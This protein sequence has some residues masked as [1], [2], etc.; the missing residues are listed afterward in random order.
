MTGTPADAFARLSPAMQYQV[1]NGLG[2]SELRLVQQL[3]THAILDGANCVVLAP[4]AGGKTEAAFFPLLSQMDREDWAPVS[5]LYIAPIR[6]LLNNQDSRLHK[7]TALVGRTAG[8]WHG[9]VNASARKNM[10]A[11]PPDVLAITPESLEAML[12]STKVPARRLLGKVR[13]VV[14]DEVHAFAGDDRGAHLVAL[15]ERISRIAEGDIQRIGLSATVGDPEIILQWLSGSS[16]RPQRIVNPGGKRTPPLISVDFVGS[17]DNAAMMIDQ[18]YPGTRRLVFVDSRRRVE[19]LGHKLSARGVNVYLSHSSLAL[20]E[21]AAAEKAFEEGTNCVIVATSA[22]ELGIDVGDL[23]HVIQV[24]APGTVSSC[25]QRMGRT[26]RRA[27]TRAN[28]TFLATDEAALLQ[29]VALV[30]L[31]EQGFV[32]PAGPT[33]WAPHVLAHQAIALAMQEQ[34]VAVHDWW[35]WLEGCAA[36]RD[37]S[38]E[39]RDAVV[40]HMVTENILVEADHRLVLGSKGEKLYGAKNFLELYAV[41]STPQSIRVMH[42]QQEVGI[43]DAFFLQDRD[44][45]TPSFVLGGRAWRILAVDW[46]GATCAVEPGAAG[47]YPSWFGQPIMLSRALCQS[48]R[49]LLVDDQSR[50][51]WSK[52]AI[53]TMEV[54]RATHAF[55]RDEAAPLV[56]DANDK[57]KWWTFAGGKGN[58]VLASLLEAAL[59]SRVIASNTAITFTDGAAKSI[60]GI[61][62]AIATLGDSLTWD[63]VAQFADVGGRARVSKFQPCLPQ[64]IELELV[65]REVMDLDDAR[66]TLLPKNG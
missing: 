35:K 21:R 38:A 56:E 30:E 63:K 40:R 57:V 13:A 12:L 53:A 26:G 28:C 31:L 52:R 3:S 42:G 25:L 16:L 60:V 1:V 5:V 49:K 44:R 51:T 64:A 4:T 23:D 11:S 18:L 54:Q 34:G 50:P 19:E 22:L 62:E 6:A 65:A 55:L 7:L 15:L 36:L 66:L 27:G 59:G 14:I 43:V 32:E 58:R 61:R 9:D 45:K 48:M 24:D 20:S 37:V 46:K 2:W 10:I 39:Q 47:A 41:F 29:S 8:K 17:L 33:A